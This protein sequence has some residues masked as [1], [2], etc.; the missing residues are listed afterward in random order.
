MKQPSI[1]SNCLTNGYYGL[2]TVLGIGDTRCHRTDKALTTPLII[3]FPQAG[4]HGMS[5]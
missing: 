3:T 5:G 4:R 1:H 2:G